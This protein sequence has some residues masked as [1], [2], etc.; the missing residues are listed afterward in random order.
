MRQLLAS[1][2]YG[3]H[4][5]VNR[6][7]NTA[8]CIM[9]VTYISGSGTFLATTTTAAKCCSCYNSIQTSI[10]SQAD[11]QRIKL[12]SQN[13]HKLVQSYCSFMVH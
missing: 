11:V 7:G 4:S 2:A 12:L 5:I 10:Q 13:D 3:A 8:L 1:N 9:N 6:P